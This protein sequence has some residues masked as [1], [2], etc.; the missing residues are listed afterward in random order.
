MKY[1]FKQIEKKSREIQKIMRLEHY[2]INIFPLDN[3]KSAYALVDSDARIQ[4]AN[5]YYNIDYYNSYNVSE[6]KIIEI[7]FHEHIHIYQRAENE[8]VRRILSEYVSCSK[9]KEIFDETYVDHF[10]LLI[11]NLSKIYADLYFQN[12]KKEG[13]K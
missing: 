1:T 3:N 2:V 7:M 12:K 10:E 6:R 5:I 9:A 11:D 4:Q 8:F 13:N